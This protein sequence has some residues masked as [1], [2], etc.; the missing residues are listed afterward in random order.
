MALPWIRLGRDAHAAVGDGVDRRGH[1]HAVDRDALAE[2]DAVLESC[3]STAALD[4]SRPGG[5]AVDADVGAL[6]E[7]ERGE[8]LPQLAGREVSR[9]TCAV[10]M[11][12]DWAIT[13]A[14]VSLSVA[15]GEPVVD[16]P[17]AALQLPGHDAAGCGR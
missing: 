2:G 5:L 8:V 13:P 9:A 16:D 3:R 12:D 17:V 15:V 1:L 7:A 10:P 11:L 14:S 4:G 6:A